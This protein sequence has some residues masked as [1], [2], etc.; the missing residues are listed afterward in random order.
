MKRWLI[1]ILICFFSCCS[2]ATT[3]QSVKLTKEEKRQERKN[4]D[5]LFLVRS[6]PVFITAKDSLFRIDLQILLADSLKARKFECITYEQQND[7]TKK[8]FSDIF[9]VNDKKRM[10]ENLEKIKNDKEYFIKE[11]RIAPKVSQTVQLSPCANNNDSCIIV[12]RINNPELKN[13]SER[14]YE[15]IFNQSESV[16]K[17]ISTIIYSLINIPASNEKNTGTYLPAR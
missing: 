12:Q 14:R 2:I 16:S 13:G 9:A 6:L 15:F 4:I 1:K 10:L 5:S 8:F 7:I 17:L 3:A 11:M